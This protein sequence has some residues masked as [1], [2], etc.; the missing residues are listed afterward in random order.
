MLRPTTRTDD[1][2]AAPPYFKSVQIIK[3]SLFIIIKISYNGKI[4]RVLSN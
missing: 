2:H 1:S 3:I 4:T